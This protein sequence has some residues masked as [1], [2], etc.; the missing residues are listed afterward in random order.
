MQSVSGLCISRQHQERKRTRGALCVAGDNGT[1]QRVTRGRKASALTMPWQGA[2]ETQSPP[3]ALENHI[4]G[5]CG[6]DWPTVLT[7]GDLQREIKASGRL[8]WGGSPPLCSGLLAGSI[9]HV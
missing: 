8:G 1:S 2:G 9:N 6:N 3:G 4:S 5:L 7:P